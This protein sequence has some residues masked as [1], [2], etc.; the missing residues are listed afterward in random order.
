MMRFEVKKMQKRYRH[1]LKLSE[2]Q[3]MSYDMGLSIWVDNQQFFG[4]P[5]FPVLDFLYA[6]YKW[7][8]S[9]DNEDFAYNC[10][11]TEDNPLISFTREK[12]MWAM[13]SPW[14]LFKCEK[15]FAKEE[16][17]GALDDLEKKIYCK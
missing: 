15:R 10:I 2:V 4:E 12:N 1:F 11:E 5:D 3:R 7:K 13:Y 14:Q 17:I 16:I 6:V 9:K 8:S